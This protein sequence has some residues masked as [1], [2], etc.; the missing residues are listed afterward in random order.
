MCIGMIYAD[1]IAEISKQQK[2]RKSIRFRTYH[3]YAEPDVDNLIA[4]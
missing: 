4:C 2:I 3:K 1:G